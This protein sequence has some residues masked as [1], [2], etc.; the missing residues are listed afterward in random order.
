MQERSAAKAHDPLLAAM[1]VW[2]MLG[3]PVIIIGGAA[4]LVLY[5]FARLVF[6]AAV[7][8]YLVMRGIV[9]LLHPAWRT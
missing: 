8:V 2:A 6:A 5:L 9:W 1:F 3:W 4:I 7:L